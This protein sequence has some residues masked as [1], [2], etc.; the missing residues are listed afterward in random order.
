MRRIHVWATRQEIEPRRLEGAVAVVMDV[1]LATTTLVTAFERGARRVFPADSVQEA[2]ERSAG[3]PGSLKG[4]ELDG[5][6][7]PGFDCGPLPT[8][9]TR[10]RV[11]DRDLVFVTTNGTRAIRAAEAAERL[12]I[13]CFRN[14]PATA[15]FLN[16]LAPEDVYL[17]C[18]GS[19]G[20]LSLEDFVCAGLLTELL[21]DGH[22]RLNDAAVMAR[23]LAAQ[24][25]AAEWLAHSRVGRWL[26]SRGLEE[27]V[28]FTGEVG[29]STSVVE[30]RDGLLKEAEA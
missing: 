28:A 14:T 20:H 2:L 3:L 18:A 7:I 19:R 29:A 24:R 23:A 9:Y 27:V 10:D 8:E 13:A 15:R 11:R 25:T 1:C 26:A 12:F 6:D 16:T 17:I 4:G 22:A 5:F 21:D 30:V